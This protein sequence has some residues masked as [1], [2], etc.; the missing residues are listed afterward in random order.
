MKFD[1]SFITLSLFV[2]LLMV[3]SSS[4]SQE[5]FI[6]DSAE[7]PN[8]DGMFGD[9]LEPLDEDV[10]ER[11][12]RS[13]RA[14]NRDEQLDDERDDAEEISPIRRSDRFTRPTRPS[15]S[16]RSFGR[17][18]ALN[19][20]ASILNFAQ[21]VPNP[22][23]KLR[24]DFVQV[25]IEE[26]VKYFSERLRKKFIYDPSILSGK[27]TIVS[28]TEVSVQEAFQAFFSAMEIRGYVV[29]PTGA[30]LKIEKVNNA[31]KM[32]VPLYTETLPNDDSYVT[33]IINL[34][35]LSTNDIRRAVQDLVSRTGGDVIEH[36]PTNT[37]I[38][39]DYASNI[40]RIIRIL[41]ILDVEGFQE[42]IAVIG[43][44]YASATEVARKI[45]DIFPTGNS[46]TPTRRTT[47]RRS[48]RRTASASS[49]QEGVI[50]KVVADERTNSLIILGSERGIEQVQRF[51]KKIDVQIDGGDG[52]IHV[53][54][55]QNV[56]AEDLSQ[57]LA[58][59]AS[60][61][62]SS[63]SSATRTST[64]RATTSRATANSAADSSASL[65][66]GEIKITA[67][68]RTNSLVVQASPRDFEVLK[69][70]IRKLDIRRRQVFIES[71]ILES[72]VG[73]GSD[74]G[75]SVRG[76]LLR[77]DALGRQEGQ[78]TGADKSTGVFG[79]GGL[80]S[81]TLA[82]TLGGLLGSTA[83]T[84][85]ALGFQSGSTI[86]VPVPGQ[87]GNDAT[88]QNVPL[89]T[90]VIRMAQNNSRINVLS[91]PHILATANEEAVI[92]VG[93]EI[94]QISSNQTTESGST[95]SNFT[96]IRVA[97]E[98]TITPQINAGDYLTLTIK[99]KVNDRGAEVIPNS[100]QIA[101]T[102]REATTTAIV[103]DGQT[104][105]IGGIMRDSKTESISKVPFLGDIPILGW[106]FKSRTSST[107]KVN[108]L[109][110]ITPH[111]IRDTGDM[112]DV[113]F[114]KLRER[115]GFLKN[116]G[117][118]EQ[119]G[120]PLS[121][122]TPEQLDFLDEDYVKA[123]QLQPLP[124]QLPEQTETDEVE[125]P[126]VQPTTEMNT[127]DE[128]ATFEEVS[129]ENEEL[130]LIPMLPPLGNDSY[131]DF[132]PTDSNSES[133]SDETTP[134]SP[135]PVSSESDVGLEPLDP[136]P[137]I[138]SPSRDPQEIELPTLPELDMPEN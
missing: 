66:D 9:D 43:L 82:G 12:L 78:T 38:I 1:K 117:L 119:K 55:L 86:A 54:P 76:P 31:R 122:F 93:E 2:S 56:K 124:N 90:A 52:Q 35:F 40:R 79:F 84:G 5:E 37:L 62:K 36:S 48:T 30:Y 88:T 111:I 27:I 75:T 118:K 103:K 3:S 33:R 15:N 137:L 17:N 21:D 94:P 46:S 108:L 132:E 67:D 72:Q 91:T 20:P 65:F 71:V 34:K 95:I 8:V 98:L 123:L 136:E 105:V 81:K 120:I 18:S 42:Q 7:T 96:R 116:N 63:S 13:P 59:L 83:I 85:L 53:Y 50:Q 113:F 14:S 89:V 101:T 130:D 47:T 100:G 77:T 92:S 39:S 10:V 57:T 87:N 6:E 41:N 51:I 131:D 26:V 64:A 127:S 29:Y 110:F 25:D 45:N 44:N 74:F 73:G 28:P 126:I 4:S 60:N 102:T 112:N 97:T 22:N 107:T 61:A 135:D 129:G 69:G 134:F 125:L 106:L 68:P 99:Q 115:E 16:R 11:P 121:G 109:L 138:E 128:N 24:M 133:T 32:P 70:I 58:S 80:D 114:Q 23:E 19:E 104:I 49:A